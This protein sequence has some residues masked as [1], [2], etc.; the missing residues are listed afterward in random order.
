MTLISIKDLHFEDDEAAKR[1]TGVFDEEGEKQIKEYSKKYDK[2]LKGLE[3]DDDDDNENVDDIENE[4]NEEDIH[5]TDNMIDDEEE[6]DSQ[7]DEE[8]DDSKDVS[9]DDDGII[10]LRTFKLI[11]HRFSS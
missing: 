2:L 3:I 7:D 11:F 6:E 5:M 8:D 9:D 4:E 10:I 1:F